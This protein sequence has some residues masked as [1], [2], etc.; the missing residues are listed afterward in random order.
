MQAHNQSIL[1]VP[2]PFSKDP[3]HQVP[4]P[5]L[6]SNGLSPTPTFYIITLT[7]QTP[8][9]ALL[10]EMEQMYPTSDQPFASIP[11]TL[12]ASGDTSPVVW[13]CH[14]KPLLYLSSCHQ[15]EDPVP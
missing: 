6:I 10:P 15:L 8:P 14:A 7:T 13:I 4:E 5:P 1:D 2:D 12:P 11:P 3:T 9:A